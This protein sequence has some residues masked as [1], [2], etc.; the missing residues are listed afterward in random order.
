MSTE[1]CY[2]CFEFN[3]RN[4]TMKSIFKQTNSIILPFTKQEISMIPFDLETLS[5]LPSEFKETVLTMLSGIKS[6]G[7]AFFTIHGKTLKTGMTL[8]RPSPHTD[9]NYEPVTMGFGVGSGGG[10]GWKVGENGSPVNT[11]EHNRQYVSETGGV[12]L[13]TNYA[14]CLGWKGEYKGLPSVGGDCRHIEL[15]EPEL[16]KADTVYYGNNHFIH[17][18]IP[19]GRDIHRVF[20]RITMPQDHVF[21]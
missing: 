11:D 8:R 1:V 15:D 16:L 17:E 9:G 19:V 2:C 5:G 20:A 3:Q 14:S 6:K 13:A 18:S 10:S 21:N 4:K 7:T 12:I